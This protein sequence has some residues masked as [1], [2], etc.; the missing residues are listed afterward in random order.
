MVQD[1]ACTGGG[2]GSDRIYRAADP[3]PPSSPPQRAVQQRIFLSTHLG[4]REQLVD[5]RVDGRGQLQLVRG[6]FEEKKSCMS[7]GDYGSLHV[8]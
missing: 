2:G 6:S 5:E 8:P 1:V 7:T 3:V 4:A